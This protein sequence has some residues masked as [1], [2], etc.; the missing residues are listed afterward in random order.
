MCWRFSAQRIAP[1]DSRRR[2][3]LTRARHALFDVLGVML[4]DSVEPVA[5]IVARHVNASSRGN[6]T[7]LNDNIRVSASDA[8]LANATS[9]YALGFDDSNVVPGGHP[10]VVLVPALLAVAEERAS[11][12]RQIPEAYVVG[13]EVATRLAHAVHFEHYEKVWHPTAALGV[14]GAAAAVA[15]LEP[16]R[17]SRRLHFLR[18]WSP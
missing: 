10:S 1:L 16:P 5:K 7:V 13:F 4:A 17:D 8:A 3:A 9:G 18:G 6:S 14:F 12:G 15:R 11:T 2:T